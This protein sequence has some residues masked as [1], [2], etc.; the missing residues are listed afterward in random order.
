[1]S[2]TSQD[3]SDAKKVDDYIENDRLDLVER[4]RLGFR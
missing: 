2:K 1:L 4:K 3:V